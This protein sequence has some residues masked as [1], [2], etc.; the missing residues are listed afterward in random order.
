MKEIFEDEVENIWQSTIYAILNFNFE[1]V[2]V[3]FRFHLAAFSAVFLCQRRSA[4]I[5]TPI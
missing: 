4:P 3:A 2:S 1:G 5:E